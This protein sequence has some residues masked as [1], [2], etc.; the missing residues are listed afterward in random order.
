MNL[1]LEETGQNNPETIIFLHGIGLAGWM[2]NKQVKAFND[3]HCLVPDLP[4]HGCSQKVKP[5]SI[6]PAAD[7]IIDLIKTRAHGGKA[8][9]V[10][11]SLGAQ[12]I[13]QILSTAPEVA[14]SAFISGTSVRIRPPT[15]SFLKL[16]DQL[17]K[18]YAPIKNNNLFIKSYMRSYNMPKSLFGKFKESTYIIAPDSASRIIKES[19]LFKMPDG[20]ENANVPVLVM[21]GEKDYRIVKESAGDL[22]NILPNS[23]RAVTLKM[24]HLWSLEDSELFNHVIRNWIKDESLTD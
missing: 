11:I 1:F 3:Y 20:L 14:N 23:K 8:H 19:I 24:G 7:M 18:F 6:E 15:E 9:V 2:W 21:T 17:I 22:L 10:G 5:F 12:I 13:V 4:E 16:L